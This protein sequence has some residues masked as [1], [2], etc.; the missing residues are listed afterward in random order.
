MTRSTAWPDRRAPLSAFVGS[1][2]ISTLTLRSATGRLLPLV[3]DQPIWL[4]PELSQTFEL[5]KRRVI[6]P[7]LR[8]LRRDFQLA[9]LPARMKY[10]VPNPPVVKLL[11]LPRLVAARLQFGT[12]LQEVVRRSPGYH[13]GGKG[14]GSVNA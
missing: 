4:A 11:D 13:S 3:F 10:D 7:A 9:M 6:F 8:P 5:P 12:L 1:T 14:F 2:A